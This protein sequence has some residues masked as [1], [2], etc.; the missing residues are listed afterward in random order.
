[1]KQKTNIITRAEAKRLC[2]HKAENCHGRTVMTDGPNGE[3]VG[4]PCE[5]CI[6]DT[7]RVET[8]IYKLRLQY[9]ER[10]IWDFFNNESDM[11][12]KST[13]ETYLGYIKG[14][15]N[16]AKNTAG[17]IAVALAENDCKLL[18]REVA[19]LDR[20]VEEIAREAGDKEEVAHA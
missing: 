6:M 4:F 18:E 12:L 20:K 7:M 5:P 10:I 16:L 1:M 2:P 17:L 13:P 11:L 19:R 9:I 8:E 14:A 3:A 15:N